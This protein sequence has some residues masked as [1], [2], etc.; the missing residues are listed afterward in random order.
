MGL[1]GQ[2]PVTFNREGIW[3]SGSSEFAVTHR[4]VSYRLCDADEL[5]EFQAEPDRYVPS[6]HGCD[7][8]VFQS[9]RKLSAGKT[10]WSATHEGRLYF[11]TNAATRD[12]F[13]TDPARFAVNL[14]IQFFR[15][16]SKDEVSMR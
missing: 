3:K 8:I 7:P 9:E 4:G 12:R 5:A 15:E 13:Q 10:H 1:N 14:K 16:Q 11:F 6:L 2:S